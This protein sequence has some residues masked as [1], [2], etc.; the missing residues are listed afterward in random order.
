MGDWILNNSLWILI[1]STVLVLVF[2]FFIDKIR[3]CIARLF[4]EK[5]QE[6]NG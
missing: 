4:P 2:L 5:N 1:V 3:D 6:L